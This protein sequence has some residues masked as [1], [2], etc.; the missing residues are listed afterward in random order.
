MQIETVSKR[1]MK[2]SDTGLL[3]LKHMVILMQQSRLRNY[4]DW[5]GILHKGTLEGQS[6]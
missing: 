1:L 2:F 4:Y 5:S 6:S 3:S